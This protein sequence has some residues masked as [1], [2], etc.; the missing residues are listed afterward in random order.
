M[1]LITERVR[2]GFIGVISSYLENN[3]L[4]ANNMLVDVVFNYSTLSSLVAASLS[5]RCRRSSS[6]SLCSRG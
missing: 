6:L 3:K 4:V 5:S 1:T 2:L